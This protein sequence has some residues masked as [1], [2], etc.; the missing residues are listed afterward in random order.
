MSPTF[1]GWMTGQLGVLSI[2]TE[3]GGAGVLEEGMQNCFECGEV[4]L[5]RLQN[6]QMEQSSRQLE[7]LNAGR[8]WGHGWLGGNQDLSEMARETGEGY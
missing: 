3:E 8:A 2:K 5:G 4:D 1:L 6:S 7:V